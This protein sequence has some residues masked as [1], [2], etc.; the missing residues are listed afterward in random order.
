MPL[1]A[2][3]RARTL[4]QLMR[5]SSLSFAGITKPD[6]AAAVAATDDWIDANQASFNSALPQPFRGAASLAVKTLLFCY[7]AMRRANR[8]RAEEDG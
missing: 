2:T 1:D 6:L 5:D 4:A 8:L 3:G 7:V